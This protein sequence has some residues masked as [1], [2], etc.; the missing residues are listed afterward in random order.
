[1]VQLNTL[2]SLEVEQADREAKREAEERVGI[3]LL[4]A[5]LSQQLPI[6]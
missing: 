1:L 4:L 6:Q 2:L 5:L 3:E